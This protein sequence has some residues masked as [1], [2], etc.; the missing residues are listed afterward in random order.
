MAG[1]GAPGPSPEGT[2]QVVIQF[3]TNNN[4]A[5][6]TNTAW[7]TLSRSENGFFKSL[8][9][10]GTA[11]YAAYRWTLNGADIAAPE[12]TA[13]SYTFDS[14]SRGNGTYTVGLRVQKGDGAHASWHSTTITI[15]VQD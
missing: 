2:G 6:L 13:A 10:E 7:A 14:T 1:G 3:W 4:D 11:G 15:T 9:I 12:G 8:L 5:L